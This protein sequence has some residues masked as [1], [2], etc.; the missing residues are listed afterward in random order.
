M[1][2][3][4]A[5]IYWKMCKIDVKIYWKMCKNKLIYTEKCVKLCWFH[6]GNDNFYLV[7]LINNESFE[8]KNRW[9][10]GSMEKWYK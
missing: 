3:M 1:C 2:K 6:Y 10:F 4:G 9:L 8:K 7:I 5:K